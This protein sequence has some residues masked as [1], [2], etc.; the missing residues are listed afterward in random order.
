MAFLLYL[1]DRLSSVWSTAIDIPDSLQL[2]LLCMRVGRYVRKKLPTS[3]K[4]PAP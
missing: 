3:K 2:I 1:Y 4:H